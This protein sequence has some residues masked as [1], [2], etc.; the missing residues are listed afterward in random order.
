[1]ELVKAAFRNLFIFKE[2]Q[3]PWHMALLAACCVGAPLL[4][5]M[6]FGNFRG[7]LLAAQAGLVILHL[8]SAPFT[9]RVRALLTVAPGFIISY[10]L[11]LCFSFHWLGGVLLFVVFTF[12]AHWTVL[13]LNLRS[14]GSFFFIMFCAV[15]TCQPFDLHTIPV[16]VGYFALGLCDTIVLGL[17]YSLLTSSHIRPEQ[18]NST[19]PATKEGILVRAVIM[20][21]FVG[22][23]LLVAKLAQLQNP[24][25]VPVSC[26]AVMQGLSA[27]LTRQRSFQ[28]IL[29]TFAGLGI[30]W[31][32]LSFGLTRSSI[33]ACIIALQ[34]VVELVL[35]RNYA[36][37]VLF[38]TPM[39]ILLTEAGH[40]II[41]DPQALIRARLVDITLGSLIGLLGG[42]AMH[43][44]TFSRPAGEE[45]KV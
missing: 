29:G 6:A 2:V 14:P 24:Y 5:G 33:I 25:W 20:A 34:F 8:P 37:G 22:G 17:L 43:H 15:S 45:P 19:A 3:R 10:V 4:I 7:G 41:E 30:T 12:L 18:P 36:L 27:E 9:E 40:P 26:L 32:L 28:R 16:K 11:G 1:V 39:A 38:V 21:L 44:R 42:W 31:L 35:A 23:S 13:Q